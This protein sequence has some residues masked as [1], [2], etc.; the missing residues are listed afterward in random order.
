MGTGSADK[1]GA[2]SKQ[3]WEIR[4]I[5]KYIKNPSTSWKYEPKWSQNYQTF[6]QVDTKRLPNTP[7]MVPKGSQMLPKWS[8]NGTPEPLRSTSVQWEPN[9]SIFSSFRSSFWS[10]KWSHLKHFFDTNCTSEVHGILNSLLSILGS[11]LR[12]PTLSWIRYLPIETHV[13]TFPRKSDI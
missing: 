7:Q 2:I 4:R 6:A 11:I 12:G 1:R 5:P 13:T 8:P 3:L 9:L 10:P